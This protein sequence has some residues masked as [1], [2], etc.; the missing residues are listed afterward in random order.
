MKKF[1][2][3]IIMLSIFA[4]ISAQDPVFRLRDLDNQWQEYEDVKG[5]RL[6]VIDFWATWCQPCVKSIP[7]LNEIY[8]DF[9]PKGVNLVGISIDGTR[10]QSKIKPFVQSLG[11][12][13]PIL[14]DINSDFMSE[15]GVTAVPTMIILSSEGEVLHF[16]EGFRPGDE[17]LIRE[18][19]ESHLVD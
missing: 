18:H 11:V 14:R 15:M 10:N 3:L 19:I 12:N 5:S 13:Y 2:A 6:T 1:G 7:L 8:I 4:L 9:A 17:E 16:H